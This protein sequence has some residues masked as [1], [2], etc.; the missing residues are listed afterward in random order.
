MGPGRQV[1]EAATRDPAGCCVGGHTTRAPGRA[2]H[3]PGP[4]RVRSDAGVAQVWHASA[5]P[6]SLA[7]S[8]LDLLTHPGRTQRGPAHCGERGRGER[9]R[10]G[11]GP[12]AGIRWQPVSAAAFQPGRYCCSATKYPVSGLMAPRHMEEGLVVWRTRVRLA[13]AG[14]A[15]VASRVHRADLTWHARAASATAYTATW[16]LQQTGTAA[17]GGGALSTSRTSA[18]PEPTRPRAPLVRSRGLEV[19]GAPSKTGMAR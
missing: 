4:Q 8:C 1:P 5:A 16:V 12:A 2:S 18:S 6:F 19:E 14:D 10:G 15:S 7:Y 11:G 3:A 17:R 13:C 9:G